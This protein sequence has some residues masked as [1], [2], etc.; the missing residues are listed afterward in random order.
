M[1]WAIGLYLFIGFIMG[2]TDYLSWSDTPWW[3]IPALMIAW[4]IALVP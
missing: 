1:W 4:P 2:L 3:S